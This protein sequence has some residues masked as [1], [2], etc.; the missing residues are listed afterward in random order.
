MAAP[1]SRCGHY[2][3]ILWLL[4]SS[5]FFPCLMS[6]AQTGCLPYFHTW[7]GLSA[8]LGCRSETCCTRLAE[9]TGCKNLPS[10]HHRTTLLDCIFATK[11]HTDNRKKPVKQQYLPHV[12]LHYGELGP[13]AAEIGSLVWALELISTGFVSWQCCCTALYYWES[14]K[15]CGVEQRLPRLFGRVAITLDMFTCIVIFA[16]IA[17]NTFFVQS[18]QTSKPQPSMYA[19]P[20]LIMRHSFWDRA[21]IS[22]KYLDPACTGMSGPASIW[23]FTVHEILQEF[24]SSWDGRPWPQQT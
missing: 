1:R 17:I 12:S 13:L 19:K 9:N 16:R 21:S 22:R 11:V 4:L 15:L 2:I 7:C 18:L 6:A 24:S 23:R 8:N 20:G 3:F 14:V 5:S 10:M